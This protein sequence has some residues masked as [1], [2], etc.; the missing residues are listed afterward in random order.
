VAQP[1]ARIAETAFAR[2]IHRIAGENGPP[3]AIRA[4][5]RIVAR[6]SCA[7]PDPTGPEGAPARPMPAPQNDEANLEET[8]P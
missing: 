6:Q 8:W 4:P 3:R 7:L 2:L 5:C 1:V